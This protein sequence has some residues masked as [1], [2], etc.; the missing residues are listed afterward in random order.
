MN[1]L[2]PLEI[3]VVEGGLRVSA[4]TYELS[5]SDVEELSRQ[6]KDVK[7]IAGVRRLN[8]NEIMAFTLWGNAA[9][10]VA[11]VKR[12]LQL[13]ETV[14]VHLF[15]ARV[16]PDDATQIHFLGFTPLQVAIP[17]TLARLLWQLI[18]TLTSVDFDPQ[19]EVSVELFRRTAADLV[20]QV[21]TPF[22]FKKRD[23][24]IPCRSA[25]I[26]VIDVKNFHT[27]EEKT[28]LQRLLEHLDRINPI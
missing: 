16:V 6:L 15:T 18:D 12:T 1:K 9:T 5:Y 2:V 14:K 17:V 24:R 27:T 11:Q 3:T 4:G 28:G 8:D 19:R 26:E 21:T 20:L 22:F 25:G 23:W 10:L 7:G 13:R